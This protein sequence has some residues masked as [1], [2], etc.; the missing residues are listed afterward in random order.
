[1]DSK[2]S[3]KNSLCKTLNATSVECQ[4]CGDSSS[5]TLEKSL[6]VKKVDRRRFITNAIKIG[7]GLPFMTQ[8]ILLEGCKGG[9]GS[10]GNNATQIGGGSITSGDLAGAEM[11]VLSTSTD[12]NLLGQITL[13]GVTTDISLQVPSDIGNAFQLTSSSDNSST[14]NLTLLDPDENELSS[15]VGVT[16]YSD[17]YDITVTYDGQV[18][19]GSVYKDASTTSNMPWSFVKLAFAGTNYLPRIYLLAILLFILAMLARQVAACV[20]DNGSP[21]F[22]VAWNAKRHRFGIKMVCV[23]PTGSTGSGGSGD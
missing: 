20:M 22:T 13:N 17:K 9:D 10:S 23:S 11:K 14:Y 19:T 18:Y 2:K 3:T 12:T 6:F 15:T 4:E 1:M 8:F 21:S 16:E 5:E 7:V